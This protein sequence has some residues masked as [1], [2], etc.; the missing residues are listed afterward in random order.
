M[1]P[2][3]AGQLQ[4]EARSTANGGRVPKDF[5]DDA[6]SHVLNQNVVHHMSMDIG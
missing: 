6:A 4:V 3:G 2:S 5:Q 1:A